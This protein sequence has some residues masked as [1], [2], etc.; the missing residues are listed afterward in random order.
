MPAEVRQ[1]LAFDAVLDALDDDTETNI[2]NLRGA[3]EDLPRGYPRRLEM[4]SALCETLLERFLAERDAADVHAVIDTGRTALR[5]AGDTLEAA[6]LGLTVAIALKERSLLLREGS[7]EQARA[8]ADESIALLEQISAEAPEPARFMLRTPLG[9]SHIARYLITETDEDLTASIGLLL[10]TFD[11]ARCFDRAMTGTLLSQALQ[12]R[13]LRYSRPDDLDDAIS[14]ARQAAGLDQDFHTFAMHT[15]AS[16][17][18]ARFELR[19]DPA[20]LEESATQLRRLLQ[21]NRPGS[22]RDAYLIDLAVNHAFHYRVSRSRADLEEANQALAG[23]KGNHPHALA[24]VITRLLVHQDMSRRLGE[25]YEPG[26][27]VDTLLSRL[28]DL[29]ETHSSHG[30][31]LA[32]LAGIQRSAPGDPQDRDSMVASCRAAVESIPRG[33]L[34]RI[35]HLSNLSIA[36]RRRYPVAHDAGDLEEALD[37]A[38]QAVDLATAGAIEGSSFRYNLAEAILAHHLTT[39]MPAPDVLAEVVPLLRSI[40]QAIGALP[41]VRVSAAKLLAE[42]WAVNESW[43]EAA[44]AYEDALELLPLLT[45]RGIGRDDAEDALAAY[46]GIACDA[47]AVAI[48]A[49]DP[50]RAVSLLERGRAILW[51][52]L[53]DFRSDLGRLC[54]ADHTC[55]DE[56]TEL[57]DALDSTAPAD[58]TQRN[59]LAERWEQ[60]VAAIQ[61]REGFKD[62]LRPPALDFDDLATVAGTSRVAIVNVSKWRCDS[63][64]LHNGTITHVPLSTSADEVRK[65]AEGCLAALRMHDAASTIESLV[66]VEETL[67]VTLDWLWR[68]I[69]STTLDRASL[70]TCDDEVIWCPTGM[71]SLLP[72]HAAGNPSQAGMSVIER[73]VPSYTPTVRALATGPVR[74]P[75]AGKTL[76]VS[77]PVTDGAPPL[78][79]TLLERDYICSLLRSDGFTLLDED[80]GHDHAD[81]STVARQLPHHAIVHFGCH[82]VQRVDAPSFAGLLLRDGLLSVAELAKEEHQA[83]LVVLAACATA[84]GSEKIPDEASTL[85]SAFAYMG[86]RRVVATLWSV[87]S[88]FTTDLIQ[89]LYEQ[90][91]VSRDVQPDRAAAALRDAILNAR[92]ADPDRPGLWAAF[93]H[94]GRP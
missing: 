75:N 66:H 34:D 83:E 1:H 84:S 32:H 24:E 47:A 37:T 76:I 3:L 61:L 43:E 25:S 15:L 77:M 71:L 36:L 82:G 49:G 41:S 65:T 67:T 42:L 31:A 85:S 45:W 23:I 94:V 51:G 28:S 29:P 33:H 10:P 63:L 19:H 50:R 38:R 7:H 55:A 68:K 62:F 72:L 26:P 59:H 52:Y 90:I 48:A 73:C 18:R 53:L 11:D 88:R 40:T 8:D 30:V 81:R 60:L 14:V 5:G 46:P 74:Q 2:R 87:D 86:W 89:V 20:D 27:L 64:I 22:P 21:V 12:H 69:A 16:A 9:A 58:T 54:E 80:S 4:V 78:P 13:Y 44:A 6:R 91:I 35:G 17:L 79:Q 56:L 57:R 92:R 70:N 93:V 39:D